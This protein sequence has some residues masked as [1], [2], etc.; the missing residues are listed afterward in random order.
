[1][2]L[3]LHDTLRRETREFVPRVDG[4]VSMYV[5]G[6][7]VQS[8]P[9]IGHLRSAVAFDV[10][11]RWLEASGYTVH[12]LRNVTDIE[13]KV[14]V[15]A[16]E[17]GVPWW[18]LA[19]AV[20]RDFEAAYDALNNLPPT[21]EPRAT[22]H[23]PEMVALMQRLI[24]GG[25][26]YP[27][28]NG[29]VYFDVGS[30]PSYGSLSGQRTE[31]MQ[32][33]E[34]VAD[35]RD[36]LD[37]ALW[38]A[39][40]PGEPSWDT[41]WGPGRPGW[42]LECSAMATHYLGAGFDIHGGG[43]DLVFP[44]H[45]NERAQSS[46]AGDEFARFWLHHGL[47][48]TAGVKMSKSLGNSLFAAD[49]L[50]RARPAA[51]R[52]A[53]AAPHY[54]SGIDWSEDVLAEAESAYSRIEGFLDRAGPLEPAALPEKFVAAMD[55]D[56]ATPR[57]MAVVHDRVREGN[58][59]SDESEVRRIAGEVLAMVSVLGLAPADFAAVG[60]SAL[61]P[62]V[63]ALVPAMLAARQ[64]ARERKDYAESDRIRDALATAG[65]VVEDTPDGVRW[66]V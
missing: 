30:F 14:L 52:Y 22:G 65:V 24:D 11:R 39:S 32:S 4:L 8:E 47:V 50:T 63:D 61:R 54:R 59:A 13:D 33:T 20:T 57:A 51:L 49:L 3:R 5:C 45:E 66:R 7:T 38:K 48:N 64:S 15:N 28:G 40:K 12:H 23:V 27:A 56:L 55:D 53:L 1:V 58:V 37:F 43:L 9:H 60:G 46:A 62:V 16:T 21:G 17:R 42:H 44:H 29:D 34:D 35:K 2:G 25:H 36:P 6:P 31:A 18:A 41:P 10:V 26:A 19:T